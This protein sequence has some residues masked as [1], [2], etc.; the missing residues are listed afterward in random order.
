MS[1]PDVRARARETLDA[2]TTARDEQTP[3][4]ARVDGGAAQTF[5]PDETR[6]RRV[7]VAVDSERA[8]REA[9][10]RL[11]AEERGPIVPPTIDTLRTR[12]AR[13][14]RATEFRIADWQP[15]DSRVVFAAPFKA[16]K[17]TVVGNLVRSLAD[18]DAFLGRYAVTPIDGT[19]AL[20]DFEMSGT[21][22]DAWLRAQRIRH[23]DRVLVIPMRGLTASFNILD[24]D[25]RA[26]WVARLR[27]HQVAYLVV[28]C[29]RP[30]LDALGLDEHR[31]AGRFLVALDALLIDAG[32]KECL[33]VHHM[34]H[35]AE[36]SRGDS[37]LRDWPDVERSLFR[38]DP[39]VDASPRYIK[40]YGRDVDVPEGRLVYE[41]ATRAL[42]I[43]TGSRKDAKASDALTAVLAALEAAP[44]PLSGRAI[45]EALAASGHAR[46]AIDSALR[47]G[48]TTTAL[49][50]EEGPRNAT[51]YRL[52][53]S[54]RV[55]GSVRTVSQD[56]SSVS[57]RSRIGKRTLKRA[58]AGD[59]QRA[60]D[61]DT[62]PSSKPSFK[63]RSRLGRSRR[64]AKV[65]TA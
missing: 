60:E 50:A 8:R 34:G 23:D 30:V 42:T 39:H 49:T 5:I 64:E 16:G 54:V 57:V 11:D 55:S 20:L 12:L 19:I 41:P 58:L 27:Q 13:P 2:L 10:R 21:Q 28:D 9:R 61:P 3:P 26:T 65:P 24:P 6:E 15:L 46:D 63:A 32:I 29:L 4:S 52:P 45:K 36:R 44:E 38:K 62:D 14:L 37:R 1:L 40:A 56:T 31:D 47:L 43:T 25:V 22:L 53:A 33:V 59:E 17:T 7:Q 51:L 35:I 18:G 48:I